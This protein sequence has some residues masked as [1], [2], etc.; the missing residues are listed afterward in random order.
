[1]ESDFPGPVN[2]GSDEIVT[3]NRLAKMVMEI[4]HKDLRLRYIKGPLGVRGR[5]S[6]NRLISQKLGWRPSRPLREGLEKTYQWIEVQVQK[7]AAA[8]SC[9]SPL[10]AKG[11]S[12]T[13]RGG[14]L[15]PD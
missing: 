3:I 2:I 8:S 15:S 12:L 4:A 6:N 13:G 11:P 5:N 9:F 7:A 1:M 14:D 10:Q